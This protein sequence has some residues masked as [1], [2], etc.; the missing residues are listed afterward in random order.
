MTPRCRRSRS[1][2][3]V[4]PVMVMLL[5]VGAC[6][7]GGSTGAGPGAGPRQPNI[8]FILTD[9]LATGDLA[10]MPHVRSLLTDQGVS[11][12]NYFVSVSLCCPSRVSMLRGQ[13]AHNTGVLSNAGGNGGFPVARRSGVERS[14]IATWIR[15]AGYRTAL[16]GK[17][18]NFYPQGAGPTYLP[19]GWDDWLSPVRGD[20]GN[21][22]A[23]A[24]N[25]NGRIVGHGDSP[26][27]HLTDF[28]VQKTAEFLTRAA[29][30]DQPFFAW[31]AVDAPHVGA[32]P[33][34]Q[35]ADAFAG[36][37]APH[38]P[39]YNQA[40]VSD[41]P[42]WISGLPPLGAEVRANDDRRYRRRLQTLRGFDRELSTL[43]GTLEDNGQLDDTYLVFTSDNGF[44]LGQHRLSG[45]KQTAYDE[46]V[47]VP[48][49]VRGPGVPQ[50]ATS[51][52]LVGNIDLAS[53]FADLAGADVPGFVDGRPFTAQLHDPGAP[54]DRRAFLLEHWA[55][56][57]VNPAT[58][59]PGTATVETFS[60][61]AVLGLPGSDGS[62]PVSVIG[63]SPEPPEFHGIR[64]RRYTY[65][66]YVTG[67]VELYDD[68]A[69]PDQLHNLAATAPPALLGRLADRVAALEDC[70]AAAC[71]SAEDLAVTGR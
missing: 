59:P 41:M 58:A 70:R 3:V 61:S 28:Y 9:D 57:I 71:R 34:P 20:P 45:G 31:L 7:S 14:T 38:T 13:Y 26:D 18:L 29:D 62:P 56:E 50:G 63:E 23:Y 8:L 11:F 16:I 51:D 2:L 6:S 55:Q 32:V 43:V 33:A 44:H 42:A 10:V 27:E 24:F 65:V 22:L 36:V 64:T 19:P 52:A 4:M 66:E 67:E 15:A 37:G 35:D 47:H 46:D 25:E 53:T 60:T 49:I 30:A 17:Y 21:D 39:S 54:T 5:A 40:D 69:D 48:L 12:S 1:V 68:L